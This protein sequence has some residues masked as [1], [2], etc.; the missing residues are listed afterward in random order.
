HGQG[1]VGEIVARTLV[2]GLGFV[3]GSSGLA[4]LERRLR[5]MGPSAPPIAGGAGP[6]VPLTNGETTSATP[7]KRFARRGVARAAETA[8]ARSI[9]AAEAAEIARGRATRAAEAS[10]IAR[11]TEQ[12]RR[13]ALQ[14]GVAIALAIGLHNFA[15]GLAIGASARAGAMVLATVLVIGFA[16]HNST[17]GFG[18]VGPLGDVVPSWRWLGLVGL[19][20]GGPT[21]VGAMVGYAITG[22]FL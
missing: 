19:I 11:V 5:P 17:E 8:R 15:E 13:R 2:L 9:S 21:V 18:I 6:A 7:Q 22:V 20:A 1:S 4:V 3:I 14:R 16:L 10:E 12:S